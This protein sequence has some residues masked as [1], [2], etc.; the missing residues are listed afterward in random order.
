MLLTTTINDTMKQGDYVLVPEPEQVLV[1]DAH[2]KVLAWK[3]DLTQIQR[4]QHRR[5]ASEVEIT[6]GRL[7]MCKYIM[8]LCVSVCVCV[9]VCVC[10]SVSVSVCVCVCLCV[11]VCVCVYHI[12][13]VYVHVC[14]VQLGI[15]WL[16]L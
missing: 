5:I 13:F 2:T 7:C 1:Y 9:C 15:L 4:F 14:H 10:V 16:L 11:C 12:Q 3:W 6:V 8:C